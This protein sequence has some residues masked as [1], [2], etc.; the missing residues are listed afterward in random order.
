MYEI[1]KFSK[2]HQK[3]DRIDRYLEKAA[4]TAEQFLKSNRHI[5]VSNSDEGGATVISN[6]YKVKKRIVVFSQ[7]YFKEI[8]V[9]RGRDLL[10][11]LCICVHR[12]HINRSNDSMNA[13]PTRSQNILNYMLNFMG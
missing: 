6:L 7:K 13:L 10:A 5:M 1:T 3:L 4:N 11:L 8:T 12:V 2:Q 9:G